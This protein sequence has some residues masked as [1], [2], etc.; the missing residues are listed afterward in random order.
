MIKNLWSTP[1]GFYK[2]GDSSFNERLFQAVLSN[3]SSNIWENDEYIYKELGDKMLY[4]ANEVIKEKEIPANISLGRAWVQNQNP[5]GTNTPHSHA[6]SILVGV[7]YLQAN[8]DCGDLLLQNPNAGTIWSG[9][10]ENNTDCRAYIRIKP[11]QGMIVIFPGY[12]IHSVEP[13]RS[14]T[15]RIS[16]ATNFDCIK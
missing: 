14:N 11:Q 7:Y 6:R 5:G 3:K 13:N 4:C 12:V 9:A 1:V 2:I 10:I 8:E 16:I 15:Q